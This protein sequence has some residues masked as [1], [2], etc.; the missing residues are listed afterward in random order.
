MPIPA[1][2]FIPLKLQGHIDTLA[3]ALHG[4]RFKQAQS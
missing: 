1:Q 2:E 4:F 3:G